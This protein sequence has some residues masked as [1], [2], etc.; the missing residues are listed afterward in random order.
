[1]LGFLVLALMGA[2]L[3]DVCGLEKPPP[4]PCPHLMNPRAM[5]FLGHDEEDLWVYPTTFVV[6][7]VAWESVA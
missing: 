2:L 1:M 3:F 4:R 5:E 6:A 7:V